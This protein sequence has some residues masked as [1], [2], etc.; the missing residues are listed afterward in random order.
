MTDMANLPDDPR[1][2]CRVALRILIDDELEKEWL[3]AKA[4]VA[5]ASAAMEAEADM[6]TGELRRLLC[7]AEDALAN[8]GAHLDG[9]P[10]LARH[11][12]GRDPSHH[13]DVCI[14]PGG[15]VL[16][17][18]QKTC[19]TPR[20]FVDQ[21]GMMRYR[22]SKLDCSTCSFEPTCCPEQPQP[23]IP[24]QDTTPRLVAS[25]TGRMVALDCA[26]T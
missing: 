26:V 6:P 4:I 12:D 11:L 14:C 2:C 16:R 8:V 1:S 9:V 23:T 24:V 15:K 7:R 17:H 13:A 21:N 19:R 3:D 22:A 25:E 20:Q 18:R 5:V 10:E